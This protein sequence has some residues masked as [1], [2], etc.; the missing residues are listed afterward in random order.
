MKQKM[1]TA[2][3]A[4]TLAK[5]PLGSQEGKGVY[6]VAIVRFFDPLSGAWWIVT[7]GEQRGQDWLFFGLVE[8]LDREWGYFALSELEGVSKRRPIPIERDTGVI[9]GKQTVRDVLA[10]R[11]DLARSY[12]VR[13]ATSQSKKAASKGKVARKGA[14]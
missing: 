1:V 3:I 7:E 8:V 6:A 11:G 10:D 5:Y 14:R 2:D 9:P 12:S 13:K 4:R